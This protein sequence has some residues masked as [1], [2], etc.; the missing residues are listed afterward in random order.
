MKID[1]PE[2]FEIRGLQ[3]RL[4]PT[5]EQVASLEELEHVLRAVWNWRIRESETVEHVR[6]AYA[7]K[8]GL[9]PARPVAP[10][11]DGLTPE[12]SEAAK[13]RHR[14]EVRDWY[15]KVKSAS[16][17]VPELAYRTAKEWQE[18]MKCN[19]DYQLLKKVAGWQVP[20][21]TINPGAHMFQAL[22]KNFFAKS[23]RPK[24]YRKKTD[25]MPLQARS[26]DDCFEVGNFGA[27]GKNESFYDCQVSLGPIKKIRGRLPGKSPV[28]RVLEGVS[29]KKQ[30]DGWWASIKQVVP[31]RVLAEAAPGSVIGIDVGL[32]TMAALSTPDGSTASLAPNDR[33][34]AFEERIAGRQAQKKGV[35][36]LQQRAARHILHTIYNQIVKPLERAEVIGIE[37]LP[38]NI[39]QRGSVRK[40]AMRKIAA[41]VTERYGARV[42]A[43][44]PQYTSQDCSQCG[45]RSKESWSYERGPIGKCPACGY[46][47]DRDLNAARN[48][49]KRAMDLGHI[50][51]GPSK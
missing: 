42:R 43:V 13:E 37:E 31:K 30:A 39:G 20:D 10:T 2:G 12:A 47:I 14:S 3:I 26:G 49:A 5:P 1:I 45:L 51:E 21:M 35:G 34:L 6:Q 11:Y 36:R 50:E 23:D 38:A 19:H 28:G 24:R 4:Y 15:S 46:Q 27:R 16:K 29:I 41:L 18:Q 9:V 17:D 32:R 44:P 40:S 33:N 7:V 22:S 25:P 48:I 8:Q